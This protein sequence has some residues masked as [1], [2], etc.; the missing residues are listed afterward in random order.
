MSKLKPSDLGTKELVRHHVIQVELAGQQNVRPR[1]RVLDQRQIDRLRV[2]NLISEDQFQAGDKL[3][4]LAYKAGME[5]SIVSNIHAA[6]R[7]RSGKGYEPRQLDAREKVSGA[8]GYIEKTLK[9]DATSILIAVVINDEPL[10][11]WARARRVSRGKATP[12]LRRALTTL[13]SYWEA[14]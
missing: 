6:I 8:L 1:A 3:Y 10:Y 2:R 7:V 4:S 9:Q 13:F 14:I 5:P 12:L 11:Q